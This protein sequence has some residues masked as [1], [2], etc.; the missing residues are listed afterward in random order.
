M[1]TTVRGVYRN[2]RVELE[3]PLRNVKDDS[4][5]IVTFLEA[6][7]IDLRKHGIDKR[8]A[9]MLRAQLSTF[10]EEWNSP[11]MNAYDHYNVGHIRS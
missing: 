9:R 3:K 6:E 7:K 10:A 8:Q 1:L 2:G 4:P 11:E 5:V